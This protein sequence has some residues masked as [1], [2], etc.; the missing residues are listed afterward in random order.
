MNIDKIEDKKTNP[1]TK[2]GSKTPKTSNKEKNKEIPKRVF[3]SID[4]TIKDVIQ[5]QDEGYNI[6]F[7]DTEGEFLQ[8]T[9]EEIKTL[10]PYNRKKYDVAKGINNKTLDLTSIKTSH[11]QFKPKAYHASATNRL[12]IE[13]ENPDMSYAW[14]RQDE[15]Q[16]VI[17]DGGRVCQDPNVKTF[18][19]FDIEGVPIGEKDSTH[20][21]K[22]NGEIELVL[23]ETPK[24]IHKIK[25]DAIDDLSVRRN[26]AVDNTAKADLEAMGGNPGGVE[27]LFKSNN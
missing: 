25:R 13:N 22:A 21:V 26:Q 11:M 4:N 18:G 16:Q 1:P 17:Y 27:R 20:Y 3:I 2:G 12:K 15:L 24:E 14:K 23:T 7:V 10:T 6:A 8:L 9:G 5:Y 19:D